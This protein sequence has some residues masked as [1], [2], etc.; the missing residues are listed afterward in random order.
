[1]SCWDV[2]DMI[3]PSPHRRPLVHTYKSYNPNPQSGFHPSYMTLIPSYI[4]YSICAISL[5]SNSLLTTLSPPPPKKNPE[6]KTDLLS[7]H[8]TSTLAL[9]I[10]PLIVRVDSSSTSSWR[11]RRG[12]CDGWI[13]GGDSCRRRDF[14]WRGDGV[15]R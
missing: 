13:S 2:Y 11:R 7:P 4:L 6:N 15:E 5:I 9:V 12:W 10:V 3:R 1:M 14:H 8:S